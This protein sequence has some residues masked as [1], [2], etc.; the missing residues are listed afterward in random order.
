MNL[1]S[2]SSEQTAELSKK[3]RL[4]EPVDVFSRYLAMYKPLLSGN[5]CII[6]GAYTEVMHFV[7]KRK[8][9]S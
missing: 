1:I 6:L 8:R 4:R 2:S 3:P 9:F 5:M 7:C